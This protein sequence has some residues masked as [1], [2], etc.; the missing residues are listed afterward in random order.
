MGY[1]FVTADR[2]QQ[3]LLPPDMREWLAEDHVVWC[4]LD[5]VGQ[6]DL[7]AFRRSFRSNGQGAAAFDPALMVALLL[8]AYSCGERS[9]RRIERRCWEDVA[10]R[11]ITGGHQPDH[12]TIARFRVRHEKALK[13]LFTQVLRL[14]AEAGLV[15]LNRLS[16]D[17]TKIAADASWSANKTLVQV[18]EMLAEAAATDAAEHAQHG[19]A[20]G[21]ETPPGMARRE[22]RLTRL[23]AARDRL[24]EA[25]RQAQ[26]AQ[27]TK[28]AGWQARKD[29]GNR[30]GR[31]PNPTPPA[32]TRNQ[33]TP[34]ANTTDPDCRTMKSKH[35]LLPGYNA[36]A[37]V[38][39]DQ[40]VVGAMLTQ[41][42]VDRGLLH[43]VLDTCR[44]QLREA[45]IDPAIRTVL[46]DAGYASEA[47]FARGE[48]DKLRLLIPL[49]KDTHRVAG[50][51]PGADADLDHL[52]ATA[53][54]QRRLRH[55]K[56]KADYAHRG[57]TVE[58]VFG[59]IKT[60]QTLTR[61]ARRGL[62]ACDSEW[63]L[64]ATAHNLLKMHTAAALAT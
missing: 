37:V 6:L 29:A 17:G 15:Q 46:A 13:G 1:N 16:L 39:D 22:D 12:A 28:L 53:R 7:S 9:S 62:D 10:Y 30:P 57:R 31:K 27:D 60:R 61:F 56:G 3:F 2:D 25:A 38:T 24:A 50:E 23:R 52:P 58:P 19:P 11:V 63:H 33:A 49:A 43:R 40:V 51:D 47:D 34:R 55:W 54:A 32:K 48:T 64:A 5:A 20:R 45:G 21:D 8:Y 41:A 18:E 35:T 42:P 59:Q 44:T 14:L 26:A 36:Q 4:V